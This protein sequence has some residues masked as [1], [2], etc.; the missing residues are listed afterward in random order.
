[1]KVRLLSSAQEELEEA[2][3]FYHALNPA[4]GR[5]FLLDARKIRNQ[6]SQYPLAWHPLDETFR[7]CRSLRFPYAFIYEVRGEEAIVVAVAHLRRQPEYWRR[8]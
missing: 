5:A 3:A 1:M 7:Q 2:T 4:L 8:H 6:I